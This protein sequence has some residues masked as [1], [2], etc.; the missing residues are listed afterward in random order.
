[1]AAEAPSVSAG[2]RG[3][4]PLRGAGWTASLRLRRTTDQP[5]AGHRMPVPECARSVVDMRARVVYESMYGNTRAVAE[6]VAAALSDRYDVEVL[7]VHEAPPSLLGIELLV[8]G[9]PT[10]VHGMASGRSRTAAATAGEQHHTPMDPSAT[11][12]TGLRDWLRRLEVEPGVRAAAFD[13]RIDKPAWLTG[14]A[15]RGIARRLRARR[16]DVVAVESFLVDDSEGP[17]ADGEVERAHAWAAGL[18]SMVAAHV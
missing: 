2:G 17:L 1:M 15:A 16:L 7:P 13:T 18:A 8:V 6:A 3:R 5:C 9:G 10:H 11:A 12:A 14:S 4:R